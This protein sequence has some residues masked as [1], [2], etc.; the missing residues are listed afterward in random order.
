MGAPLIRGECFLVGPNLWSSGP[1]LLASFDQGTWSDKKMGRATDHLLSVVPEIAEQTVFRRHRTLPAATAALA[2]LLNR[3]IGASCGR[4][5]ILSG[6]DGRVRLTIACPRRQLARGLASGINQILEALPGCDFSLIEDVLTSV[7]PLWETPAEA[8]LLAQT[9]RERKIPVTWPDADQ[10]WLVLGQGIRRQIYHRGYLSNEVGLRDL[11][12][13][14]LASARLLERAGL[15]NTRPNIVMTAEQAVARAME[16]GMPVVLKPNR[17]W[18]QVGVWTNLRSPEAIRMAFR[19]AAEQS[20]ALGGP[21]LIERHRQGTYLR[22]TLVAGELRAAL[23]N[24]APVMTGDGLHTAGVLAREF[25]SLPTH[26]K[27]NVRGQGILE[28]VLSQQGLTSSS[29]PEF[30]RSFMVGHDNQGRSVD[31]TGSIHPSLKRLLNRVGRLF[32]V[33]LL[34]VDM[35]VRDP[36]AAFDYEQDAIIEVNPA[37]AFSMH[38]RPSEGRSRNLAGATLTHLFPAG[39]AAARVPVIAGPTGCGSE[40]EQLAQA[41]LRKG[42]RSAGYTR[43]IAW[44]GD[45]RGERGRGPL[46]FSLLPLDAHAE[47]LLF[48]VDEVLAAVIGL[49]VD[50]VDFLVSNSN[51]RGPLNGMLGQLCSPRQ[52]RRLSVEN[53][54]R[55]CRNVPSGHAKKLAPV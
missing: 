33:P 14:K 43:N 31:V 6:A 11:A 49:P 24:K 7:L 39:A 28:A 1:A 50:R 19:R 20:G 45:T 22:A 36:S 53:V 23:T 26:E 40:L 55:A 44:S 15:P 37:P 13:D 35:I 12:D 48:E 27:L 4:S 10:D 2:D 46:G 9:A 8:A 29:I 21:L 5:L 32:A 34:G 30:G 25:Y 18:G 42:V 51:G 47:V 16:L 52:Q 17:G 3:A 41:L 38:E 54:Q